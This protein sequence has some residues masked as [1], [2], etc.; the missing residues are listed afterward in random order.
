ME[1]ED[2]KKKFE[3]GEI[4]QLQFWA[5]EKSYQESLLQ[6]PFI[7]VETKRNAATRL[8]D[9]AEQRLKQLGQSEARDD[10]EWN[11]LLADRANAIR[12]QTLW[13]R[14]G[15]LPVTQPIYDG[16]TYLDWLKIAKTE[17]D[18]NKLNPAL[19]GIAN[20]AGKHE[21]QEMLDTMM[22]IVRRGVGIASE[23][24]T[25][26]FG[27]TFVSIINSLDIETRFDLLI[28][29]LRMNDDGSAKTV[30]LGKSRPSL[31]P[32]FF[33][34]YNAGSIET[35]KRKINQLLPELKNFS[36]TELRTKIAVDFLREGFGNGWE[37]LGLRENPIACELILSEI[38]ARKY[39]S[40][41]YVLRDLP[42]LL[43]LLP[44]QDLIREVDIA[45]KDVLDRWPTYPKKRRL[46]LINFELSWLNHITGLVDDEN[47]PK[48]TI[49]ELAKFAFQANGRPTKSINSLLDEIDMSWDEFKEKI[50]SEQN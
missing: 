25:T 30:L 12:L 35:T 33:G 44:E 14:Q 27:H 7:A 48:S 3:N 16:K 24:Q 41:N 43:K 17:R 49:I 13:E 21:Q 6:S 31:Q 47:R 37:P 8:I 42:E 32:Y 28:D 5:V 18:L 20:L 22:Q 11:R 50:A 38:E 46:E 39:P 29:E 2:A 36:T 10:S 19:K 34:L 9:I 23:E 26:E 40:P 4:D 15:G 45:L 1:F